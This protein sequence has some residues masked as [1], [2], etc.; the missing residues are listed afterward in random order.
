MDIKIEMDSSEPC[1]RVLIKAEHCVETKWMVVFYFIFKKRQQPRDVGLISAR[2]ALSSK[3]QC[4]LF[5]LLA[6]RRWVSLLTCPWPDPHGRQCGAPCQAHYQGPAS[7]KT[8]K[9]SDSR[10]NVRVGSL[11]NVAEVHPHC[12][13]VRPL[14]SQLAKACLSASYS[15][16]GS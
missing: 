15:Y 11:L 8:E 6:C 3:R 9:F 13:H 16:P 12:A 4:V 14:Y 10:M 7:G 1:A 2:C 5:I